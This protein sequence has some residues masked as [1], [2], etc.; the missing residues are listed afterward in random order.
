MLSML[1][2]EVR[3]RSGCVRVVVHERDAFGGMRHRRSELESLV[4]VCVE[5]VVDEQ[6]DA[7]PFEYSTEHLAGVPDDELVSAGGFV[8]D[9][10]EQLRGK[11]IEVEV[12]SPASFRSTALADEA[13]RLGA[14]DV[15]VVPNGVELPDDVGLE[16]D[17][18]GLRDLVVDGETGLLLRPGDVRALRAALERLLGDSELRRRLGAAGR[19]RARER[20]SW[21]RVTAETLRAYGDVSGRGR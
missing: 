15:R 1:A 9:A 13:R 4:L 14:S 18:G 17:F 6:T 7:S 10:V 3:Q 20:F 19:E 16:S 12:V 21:E 2:A 8:A 11:G 5:A